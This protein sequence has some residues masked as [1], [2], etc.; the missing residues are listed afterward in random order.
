MTGVALSVAAGVGVAVGEADGL[1]NR[2][3]NCS[4]SNPF[5]KERQLN[6]YR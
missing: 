3:Y 2:E 4:T 5:F 6:K 1:K